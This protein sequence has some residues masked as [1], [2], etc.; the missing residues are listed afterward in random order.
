MLL[1]MSMFPNHEQ[2]GENPIGQGLPIRP[3]RDL[4]SARSSDGNYVASVA[5]PDVFLAGPPS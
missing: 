3:Y 1:L 2:T 4:P 5:V